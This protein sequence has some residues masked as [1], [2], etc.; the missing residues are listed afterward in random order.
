MN[1]Y[2]AVM[3]AD[4]LEEPKLSEAE[5]EDAWMVLQDKIDMAGLTEDERIVVDCVVFGG[6]SLAETGNYLARSHGVN[7]AVYK[8]KVHRIR[9]KA[10]V[11]LR[12]VFD[13]D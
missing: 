4:F 6:M 3:E 7:V 10:F 2:Q 1:E 12:G 9:E 5:A 11:K 8:Q 13:D